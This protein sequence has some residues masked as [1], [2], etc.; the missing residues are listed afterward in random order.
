MR[1]VSWWILLIGVF[2]VV[3]YASRWREAFKEKQDERNRILNKTTATA[4]T[5]ASKNVVDLQL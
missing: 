3:M 1:S 4:A 5:S 2:V